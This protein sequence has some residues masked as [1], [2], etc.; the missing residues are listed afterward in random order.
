MVGL[1]HETDWDDISIQM[2]CDRADVARSSFYVHFDNKIALLDHV[3]AS[4]EDGVKAFVAEMPCKEGEIATLSWL[5][6]HISESRE[7]YY[8]ANRSISGQVIL[9]R[10]KAV[11]RGVFKHE[12]DDVNILVT[13]D[14]TDFVL[15]GVFALIQQWIDSGAQKSEGQLKKQIFELAYRV[16]DKN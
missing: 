9:S 1:L 13:D 16:I 4:S 5:V 12:M 6:D 11:M 10:F 7:L 14:Q 3:F 8:H 2:I 15:G